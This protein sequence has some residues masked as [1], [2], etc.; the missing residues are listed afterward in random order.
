MADF[1]QFIKGF[2]EKPKVEKPKEKYIIY[3]MNG[4]LVGTPESNYYSKIQD[5]NKIQD[6]AGFENPK[7]VIDYL[8]KYSKG[9]TMDDFEVKD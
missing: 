9:R 1:K 6:Y 7:Q 5:A 3:A 8:I 4:K 2:E